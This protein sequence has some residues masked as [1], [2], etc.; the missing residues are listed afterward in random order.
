MPLAGC[1]L[2]SIWRRRPYLYCAGVRKKGR[3][4]P[5]LV[6]HV[7]VFVHHNP[8]ETRCAIRRQFAGFA[9]VPFNQNMLVAAGFPWSMD[10]TWG[11]EMIDAVGV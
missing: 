3:Q 6:A 4:M 5:L 10:R 9:R 7:S 2:A 8:V 11:D 1:V